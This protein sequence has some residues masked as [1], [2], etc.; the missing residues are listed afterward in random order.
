MKGTETGHTLYIYKNNA[1]FGTLNAD[2]AIEGDKQKAIH[3]IEATEAIIKLYGESTLQNN[4][5]VV[6]K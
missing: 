4:F 5:I 1:A 2:R 6:K 3:I